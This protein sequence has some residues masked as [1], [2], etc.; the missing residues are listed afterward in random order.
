MYLNTFTYS[1]EL[2]S[3]SMRILEEIKNLVHQ[4]PIPENNKPLITD[5]KMELLSALEIIICF[6]KQ[7]SG[8]CNTLISD[9]IK[10]WMK[11]SEMNK[12]NNSSYELLT[13]TRLQ[14]KHIVALYELVE[15]HIADIVAEFIPSKYQAELDE[16]I[17]QVITESID[18]EE[19][20][21]E[22]SAKIPSKAFLIALKRLIVR[23]LSTDNEIIKE[24]I[25][26]S[27]YLVDDMSL[28][29]WP[30]YVSV[31]VIETKFPTTL[32]TSHIY[33]A[34][35]FIKKKIHVIDQEI[36][37]NIQSEQYNKRSGRQNRFQSKRK[38]K[39]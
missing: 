28:G 29:C 33:D 2:F 32:L 37:Q 38:M 27:I 39:S 19:S 31:N 9:Y 35:M 26:L 16:S 21:L 11:L 20:A 8:D 23:Y 22:K 7:T 36:T 14:L 12:D 10:K 4:E 15:E 17:M 5:N 1:N 25:P 18:F 6:L 30:D 3:R 24:N 34:Y 13:R